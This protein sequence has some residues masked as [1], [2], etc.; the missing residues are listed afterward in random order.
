[1]SVLISGEEN[2]VRARPSP[3]VCLADHH[4]P[5]IGAALTPFEGSDLHDHTSEV[6]RQ[7]MNAFIP[8]QGLFAGV[9][10]FDAALREPRYLRSQSGT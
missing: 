8:T 6:T 9:I 7:A 4:I 5:V 2:A 1:V 3:R 10:D